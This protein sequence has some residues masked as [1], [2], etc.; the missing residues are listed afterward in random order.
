MSK[1]FFKG[2][3]DAREKYQ[4]YGHQTKAAH[5]AGSQKY[6]LQL[7]VNSDE[8]KQEIEKVVAEQGWFATITVDAEQEENTHDLDLLLAKAQTQRFE[9]TPGRNDP[10]LCG[11]GKKY[12]KC[13]A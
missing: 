11:S 2:R 8:R 9:K 1:F 12:K 10:C 13:C 3:I 7:R 4:N 5:K 6:P